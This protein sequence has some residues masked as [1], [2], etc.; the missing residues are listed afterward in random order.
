MLIPTL[1]IGTVAVRWE[2]MG[3]LKLS[4][5]RANSSNDLFYYWLVVEREGSGQSL[6]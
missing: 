6:A 4:S 1:I 5:V 2:P 3:R